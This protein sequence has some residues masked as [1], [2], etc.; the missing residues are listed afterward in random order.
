M[1]Q[2]DQDWGNYLALRESTD[3]IV[4]ALE[5]GIILCRSRMTPVTMNCVVSTI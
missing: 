5:R 1:Y 2:R 4:A 3:H